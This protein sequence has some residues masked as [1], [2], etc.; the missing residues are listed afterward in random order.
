MKKNAFAIF[1]LIT[2]CSA[3]TNA[4][5]QFSSSGPIAPS[6]AMMKEK[7]RF[8]TIA[9]ANGNTY[10]VFAAGP[11]NAKSAIVFV[12]DYFGISN[13][14]KRSV[15]R[16]GTLGY[17]TIAV[18][19]YKGK[20][21]ITNDAAVALMNAKDANETKQILQSAIEY[22]KRPG[23]KLASVGFS[24]GGIDAMNANLIAPELFNATAIVYGGGYDKI[25]SQEINKIKSPLLAIT[26]GLDNWP[27]EAALSFLQNHKDKS[28][29]LYVYPGA[30]H[31]YA[32]P[33]FNSGKNYNAE[34]TRVTWWLLKDFLARNLK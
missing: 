14:A 19:L 12:H 15:E 33:L 5:N 26:G 30:E 10:K 22:L 13:A 6:K 3:M 4:Q 28:F 16:L 2:M 11:E 9:A 20:S 29:E 32:Q 18:D 1:T 23:R 34:A 7:G 21:A 17:R 8:I 31:G 24:A 25:G 27:L